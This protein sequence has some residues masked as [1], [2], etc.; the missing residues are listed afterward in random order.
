M[1]AK[2]YFIDIRTI[3]GL[4]WSLGNVYLIK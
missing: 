2:N 4:L 3:I 1:L